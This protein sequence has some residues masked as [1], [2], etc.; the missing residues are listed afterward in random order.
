MPA[1]QQ[2]LIA[3]GNRLIDNEKTLTDYGIQDGNFIV[4]MIAKVSH[5]YNLIL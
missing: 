1:D 5:S 4:I 2:T 3:Y